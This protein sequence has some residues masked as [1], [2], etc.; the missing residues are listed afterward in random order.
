[1]NMNTPDCGWN[2]DAR[3]RY[4]QVQENALSAESFDVSHMSNMSVTL[5]RAVTIQKIT[6][7][8]AG[9]HYT[10]LAKNT[11]SNTFDVTMP[12]G[13]LTNGTVAATAGCMIRI[14]F[15]TDGTNL[16]TIKTVLSVPPGGSE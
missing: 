5:T 4:V 10:L 11:G 3:M 6:G 13:T 2:P 14:D 1:M 15:W 12:S 16:Y 7:M 9:K 8:Q